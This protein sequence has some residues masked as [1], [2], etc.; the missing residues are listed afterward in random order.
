MEKLFQSPWNVDI[1]TCLHINPTGPAILSARHTHTHTPT[2]AHTYTHI[3]SWQAQQDRAFFL[4][5]I[6]SPTQHTV[7]GTS[8]R[9]NIYSQ[10][11][12]ISPTKLFSSSALPFLYTMCRPYWFHKPILVAIMLWSGQIVLM[13]DIGVTEYLHAWTVLCM[14][15]QDGV[16]YFTMCPLKVL[17]CQL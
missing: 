2:Q 16:M 14:N 11:S 5:I 6:Y 4:F 8:Y 17:I 7:A 9:A 12:S 3:Q 13:A 10:H 1:E 15:G